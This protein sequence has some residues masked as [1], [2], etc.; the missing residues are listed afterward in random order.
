[1]DEL[2]KLMDELQL[3]E[4]EEVELRLQDPNAKETDLTNYLQNKI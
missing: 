3:L 2:S 4:Q 1:M